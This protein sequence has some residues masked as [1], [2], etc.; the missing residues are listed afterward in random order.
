LALLSS[1]CE[2]K[3][4]SST[5][6]KEADAGETET[7]QAVD[8]SLAKAVAQ[9][10]KSGA[11]PG[12]KPD[13][14]DGPPESGVFSPGKADELHKKGVPPTVKL[15]Q[16]G[17]APRK[18]LTVTMAPGDKRKGSVELTMRSGRN[19]LPGIGLD[20]S[21]EAKKPKPEEAG[22]SISVKVLGAKVGDIQG[23]AAPKELTDQ[24]AKM[25]GSR[26]DYRMLPNGAAVDPRYDL[27]KG[28][29][30]NLNMVLRSLTETLTVAS[31]VVPR[32]AVGEGAFWLVT[33]REFAG[34]ADVIVYRLVKLDAIKG[35]KLSVTISTKR[36]AAAPKLT[37][38]GLPPGKDL[39]LEQYQST[40]DGQLEY[41]SG[42]ALPSSGS[43][44]SALLA[45][46]SQAGQAPDQR[47][48]VQSMA[49]ATLSMK[50]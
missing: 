4:S 20:L 50:E 38:M 48:G 7:A 12:A 44:K 28:A 18:V 11:T 10:E 1:G 26:V 6:S 19:V 17:T 15:G 42:R 24:I 5:A 41:A 2:D 23:Q 49:D 21:F 39:T 8:P 45:A 35:D 30:E 47:M 22:V 27:V 29:D 34:G 31:L 46:L 40:S 3:K 16:A 33:S 9:V 43:L 36:Y 14:G 32:E 25:K 37:L 13:A